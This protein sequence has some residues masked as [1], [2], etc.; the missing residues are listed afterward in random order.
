MAT[1]VERL[2]AAE[3]ELERVRLA[4][5]R[6]AAGNAAATAEQVGKVRLV[7]QRLAAGMTAADLRSLVGDIR[8]RFGTEPGV[9]VLLAEGPEGTVPFVVASNPAAQEAGVRA[10]DPSAWSRPRSVAAAA[11]G[12]PAQGSGKD[13]SG[14]EAALGAVRASSRGAEV[15]RC[16]S[17][18][19]CPTVPASA[20]RAVAVAWA[21]TSAPS[22]SASRSVT[23][24]ASW[25]PVETVRSERGVATCADSPLWWVNSRS[26]R[27]LSDCRAPWPTGPDHRREAIE[28]A[29]ALA[30]RIA[31]VPVRLAD[32]R[33]TTVSA[34]R[35]LR[36]A[37]VRARQQRAMIDQAAAVAILQG[38]LDQRRNAATMLKS[39]G[40]P[41]TR[42]D[43]ATRAAQRAAGTRRARGRRRAEAGSA[44]VRGEGGRGRTLG[45]LALVAVGVLAVVLLGP[46]L[47]GGPKLPSDYSGEVG[48]HRH[49]GP[50]RRLGSMIAQ[51][52]VE[53]GVI[54]DAG[55]FVS[56]ASGNAELAAIQPG[57]KAADGDPGGD[58]GDDADRSVLP[59]GQAGH[60]RGQTTRRRRGGRQRR[61][62]PGI[63]SLISDASCVD[64]N[65]TRSC[66]SF[67]DLKSA[68]EDDTL[69]R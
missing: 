61:C 26:S 42:V 23:R 6:A 33:L 62:E 15:R 64:L 10:N 35:S 50:P 1:L 13:S 47:L 58:G 59:G 39:D 32:E 27:L 54:A 12:G 14:I 45:L 69:G 20:T 28:F 38:W 24:T 7:A 11:A 3:K 40:D 2:R 8:S 51:N 44:Q 22:G 41:A 56:A 9:V 48:R 49:R 57:F 5:A 4:S 67:Q 25:P 52:L 60:S 66:V 29:T 16:P 34:S 63:F 36:E 68:A 55:M 65:G 30:A 53:Q 46:R 17:P 31:P 18:T 21:S 19:A 43:P 37:G